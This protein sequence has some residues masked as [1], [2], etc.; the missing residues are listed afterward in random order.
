[1]VVAASLAIPMP[2]WVP[3]Y[4]NDISAISTIAVTSRRP[5][6]TF[7]TRYNNAPASAYLG[8][9]ILT[10]LDQ[11]PDHGGCHAVFRHFDRGFNHRKGEALDAETVVAE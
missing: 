7:R 11:L 4:I 1:M 10:D 6:R 8:Q 5:G 9:E 3:A 2:N